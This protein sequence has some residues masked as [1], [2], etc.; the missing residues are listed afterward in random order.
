MLANAVEKGADIGVLERLMRL[1][2]EWKAANAKRAF[3]GALAACQNEIPRIIKNRTVKYESRGGRTS[4]QYEDLA[5]IVE[6]VKPA[7]A[8]YGLSQR[9][10]TDSTQAGFV[11][12]IC[13]IEHEDG[14]SEETALSGPYDT[15]GG[16]NAIQAIGSVVTYLQRYTLKAALGIAAARDDDGQQS[17]ADSTSARGEAGASGPPPPGTNGDEK[18]KALEVACQAL[19]DSPQFAEDKGAYERFIM[20]A[21]QRLNKKHKH[22]DILHDIQSAMKGES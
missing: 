7:M 16:K 13:I 22:E 20:K 14:H 12:V 21:N 18:W 17:R 15:S 2:E 1:S 3:S 4:Y 19:A 6:D 11:S 9:W 10:R 8:K 5:S